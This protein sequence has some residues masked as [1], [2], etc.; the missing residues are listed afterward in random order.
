MEQSQQP[1]DVVVASENNSNV[2]DWRVFPE[3]SVP[4]ETESSPFQVCWKCGRKATETCSGCS[5]AKYCSAYC[6]HKDWEHH[7]KVSTPGDPPP[8]LLIPGMTIQF[9]FLLIPS[10]SLPPCRFA[11]RFACR[12][13]DTNCRRSASG[14]QWLSPQCLA[15]H[16][17]NRNRPASRRSGARPA[18]TP[19]L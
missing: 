19:D 17:R 11:V 6:Q 16:R 7:I 12:R 1:P 4:N 8:L 15:C 5:L 18:R 2:S 10:V 13:Q 9:E 14:P 3:G